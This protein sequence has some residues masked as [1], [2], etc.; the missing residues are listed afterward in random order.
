MNNEDRYYPIEVK[1]AL[2]EKNS[3][4]VDIMHN[5]ARAW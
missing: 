3:A 4:P 2:L 5:A 1:T